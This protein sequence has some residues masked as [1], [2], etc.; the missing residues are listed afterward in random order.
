MKLPAHHKMLSAAAAASVLLLTAAC[1]SGSDSDGAS[2]TSTSAP[3]DSADPNATYDD[4]DYEA[5]AS[6]ANPG[7]ESKVKV[8][9]TIASNK[10]T[11]VEVTPEATNGESRE[12]QT[13]FAG[14]IAGKVVGKSLNDIRVSKVAGSSLTQEGFNKA[15]DQIRADAKA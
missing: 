14:G 5:E 13:K 9:L 7:G 11:A 15:L 4:G 2:G 1:G 6:Y 10:V 12:Y 8:A 3:A